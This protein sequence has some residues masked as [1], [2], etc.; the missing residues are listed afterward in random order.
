[1]TGRSV[2]IELPEEIWKIIDNNFKLNGESDSEIISNIVKDHLAH[3]H[4]LDI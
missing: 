4:E 3:I 1:M 2:S